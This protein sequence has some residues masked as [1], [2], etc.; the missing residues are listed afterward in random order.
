[1]SILI[2]GTNGMAGRHAVNFY[3]E[4]T[5][6]QVHC[7][8]IVHRDPVKHERAHYYDLDMLSF[9]DLRSVVKRAHARKVLHLAGLSSVRDSIEDPLPALEI[10]IMSSSYLLES[11]RLENPTAKV[12]MVSSSEVYGPPVGEDVRKTEESPVRPQTPYAASKAAIELITFQYFKAYGLKT[13]VARPFN[14]TGPG[15]GE[16]FVLPGFAKRLNEVR[17]NHRESIIYMGNIEVERDFLDVRDVVNAYHLLLEKG[18]PGEAYNI[19]SGLTQPLRWVLEEMMRVAGVEVEIRSD[20]R[21]ERK[22]DIPIL[23]GNNAKVVRETGW[24]P[25]IPL[26]ETLKALLDEWKKKVSEKR[27]R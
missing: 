7:L 15:Q 11:L 3:L 5:S 23:A 4:N 17:L 19:C 21:L 24:K 6:H 2:T 14:H 26:E 10:N 16:N 8:D 27:P 1:M 22:V 20:G 13:L 25:E 9:E 18:R 12:L